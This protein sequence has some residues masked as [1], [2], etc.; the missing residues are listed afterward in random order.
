MIEAI[1][2]A[3]LAGAVTVLARGIHHNTSVNIIQR[4]RLRIG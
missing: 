3:G 1:I 4:A 2:A